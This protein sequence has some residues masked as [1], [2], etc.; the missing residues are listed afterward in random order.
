MKFQYFKISGN[1]KEKCFMVMGLTRVERS[2]NDFKMRIMKGLFGSLIIH[3]S[4]LIFMAYQD[5]FLV[6]KPSETVQIEIVQP[7]SV[8][9]SKPDTHQ[10]NKNKQIVS[11]V[12]VPENQLRPHDE[13]L[14]DFLSQKKQRVQK[15]MKAAE[16]GISKNN[17]SQEKGK[18][19]EVAKEILQQKKLGIQNQNKEIDLKKSEIEPSESFE[20]ALNKDPEK[21]TSLSSPGYASISEN[22]SESIEIGSMTA[23]NTDSYLYYS[24]FARVQDLV[25]FRWTSRVE[26]AKEMMDPYYLR[27]IV[28]G[29]NWTTHLDIW[30]TPQGN[31]H[32]A[33]IMKESGVKA[34]DTAAVMAFKEAQIFSNPPQ[35]LVEE[36]GFIH[37]RYNLTVRFRSN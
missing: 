2:Y 26:A 19:R 30:L 12:L 5:N 14:A 29:R 16:S 7:E 32:S 9:K 25:R 6:G 8:K 21:S 22:I 27:N 24:F 31:Y 37:L 36:D 33:H 10:R 23:L 17:V 34:L 4:L 28:Q 35:E 18:M 20:R 13:T 15:Q 1:L 3:L 11:Q